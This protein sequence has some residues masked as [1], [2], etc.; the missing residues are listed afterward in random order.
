VKSDRTER[1]KLIHNLIPDNTF[2]NILTAGNWFRDELTLEKKHDQENYLGYLKRP[3]YELYDI[4]ND[5]FEQKNIIDQPNLK[6]EVA[7]L[8][9]NLSS[10]MQKQGDKG[11]ESELAVCERKGFSHR[12]YP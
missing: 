3:E 1:L 11:I 5:P 2:S 12:R 8:K 4:V 10:W 6:Q 9:S 7:S